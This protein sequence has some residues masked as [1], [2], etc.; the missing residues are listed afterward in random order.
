MPCDTSDITQQH[1]YGFEQ[2]DTLD[3]SVF[4][5]QESNP[6]ARQ[7]DNDLELLADIADTI[8]WEGHFLK[9][10]PMQHQCCRG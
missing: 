7:L 9:V 4:P 3:A 2:E 10:F 5:K 6:S 1:L 8:E